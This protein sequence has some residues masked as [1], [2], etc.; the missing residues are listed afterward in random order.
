MPIQDALPVIDDRRYDQLLA[1]VRTRI[2]RYT[3]EWAPVWT[4]LNDSD[5]GITLAQLFAWMTELLEYRLALVPELN[6]IKFL[7]LIGIELQPAAP[8][9]TQ[10]T[11]P[12]LDKFTDP[13][14]IVP[15]GTQVSAQAPGG[16][17]PLVFETD[18]ALVALT[19]PLMAVRWDDGFG[20]KDITAANAGATDGFE[21]F[22]PAPATGIAFLLGFG[23]AVGIPQIQLDLAFWAAPSAVAATRATCG[24]GSTPV[25]PPAT[26]A[27]D[28]LDGAIWKPL[29]LLK[30]ETRAF[31]LSGHVILKTPSAGSITKATIP[32]LKDLLWIRARVLTSEYSQ[33]PKLL[34][35]R[36]NTVA[37]T[38]AQSVEDEAL[39][40]SNGERNQVFTLGNIPVLAGSLDLQVDEGDGFTSWDEVADFFAS[41]PNDLVYTLDR[42]SG[43][44]RFG[45]GINGAIP[46]ANPDNADGNVVARVY[47]YGGGRAG[48][49]PAGAVKT[50]VN[51]VAGVDDAKVGN[52]LPS[53]GGRDEE[54]LDNAK[55][56]AP[57]LVK[58]RCRAVT[59]DDFEYLAT[60]VADVVR[61][62]ALPLFHPDFPGVRVPGVVTVIVV[63]DGGGN[64]PMPLPSEGTLK[65]VCAY[66]DQRRLLTAEV[67]VIPPTYQLV[68]VKGQVIATDSADLAEV[69]EAIEA[70]LQAYFHPITGGEAGNGWP[71]G[72]TIYFSLVYQKVMNIIGVQSIVNL[73]ISIDGV[74][75]PVCTDVPIG[76]EAL[77]Y[78]T[79]HEVQVNYALGA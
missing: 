37:A 75:A 57:A 34:A 5:P 50:M 71:F 58:S 59:A 7:Q 60:Q 9:T 77:V 49:L 48:N 33:P 36:T 13:T 41:G 67:Y 76:P 66:L 72:G 39:G 26:L 19:V 78:S 55:K 74:A 4:D 68:V 32:A 65:S 3:P 64:N 2:A 15:K 28:Y 11:F 17:P 73:T 51:T 23:A 61:A 62:K 53:S 6:Y 30:D 29:I 10:L 16:G 38:Q 25:F 69:S 79:R 14:V 24:L 22:G 8:A 20:I 43:E 40:G 45:D 35:V 54:T 1:E 63:P 42:T 56:R 21:P 46:V 18:R 31:T 12:I 47:Q 70:M 44:I 27:W 52:L